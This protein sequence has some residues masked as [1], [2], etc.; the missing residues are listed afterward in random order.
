MVIMNSAEQV[1]D[2]DE[3][4]TE[5]AYRTADGSMSLFLGAAAVAMIG[6]PWL[7]ETVWNW[8]RFFPLYLVVP[9]GICAVVSGAGALRDMRGVEGADRRRARAGLT[10][11]TVAVVVPLAVIVWA[12][13]V[14]R[15]L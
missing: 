8:L 15:D 11:G 13:W 10:L 3:L 6:C 5:P 14:M 7:P 4:D 12:L 9:T 1:L 2:P